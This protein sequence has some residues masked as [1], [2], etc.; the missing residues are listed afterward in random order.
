MKAGIIPVPR[1]REREL[2]NEITC[3][4]EKLS[5]LTRSDRRQGALRSRYRC[6]ATLDCAFARAW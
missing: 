2:I 6:G 3:F 4:N 5:L 1:R